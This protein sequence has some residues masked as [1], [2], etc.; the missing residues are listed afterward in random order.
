MGSNEAEPTT[1][2]ATA[3]GSV[4]F[5]AY[6]SKKGSDKPVEVRRF[7]VEQNEVTSFELLKAKLRQV[8][9]HLSGQDFTIGWKGL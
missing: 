8:F 2:A 9:P 1:R 6:L 4:S 5:K 3:A 7:G